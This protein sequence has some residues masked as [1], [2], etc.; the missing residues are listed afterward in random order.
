[1]LSIGGLSFEDDRVKYKQKCS[2]IIVCT[3]GRLWELFKTHTLI[4]SKDMMIIFDE[5]DKI[6]AVID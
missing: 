1:M 2:N 5:G 4:L 3:L 6:F